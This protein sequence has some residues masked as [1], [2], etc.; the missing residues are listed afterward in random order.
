MNHLPATVF[1]S[2]ALSASTLLPAAAQAPRALDI[3]ALENAGLAGIKEKGAYNVTIPRSDLDVVV[4]GFRITPAMGL[5]SRA[6]FT[7][8]GRGARVAA[9]LVVGEDR[10]KGLQQE[11][12]RQGLAITAVH[13]YLVRHSPGILCVHLGGS[14]ATAS[15]AK[16]V[17][18]VLDQ[19]AAPA[20]GGPV[21][22]SVENRLDTQQLDKILGQT[23]TMNG[24]VYRVAIGEDNKGRNAPPLTWAAWQGTPEKAAVAGDL[25]L[26][27]PGVSAVV[28]TLVDSGIEVLTVQSP[29][30]PGRPDLYLVHYW[31]TG[32]AE[33][34]AKGLK[35]AL[36]QRTKSTAAPMDIMGGD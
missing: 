31:G 16:K 18:A 26:P 36:K 6:V 1:F 15:L 30:V 19:V 34:L 21:A 11:I 13:H 24:G 7:P 12:S 25:A 17:K 35:A 10:L 14:G 27:R 23:G 20:A 3:T 2:L 5:R 28:K 29:V 8:S 9:D 4:D 33:T 32:K 22:D